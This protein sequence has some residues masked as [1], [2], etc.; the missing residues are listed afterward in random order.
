MLLA[1]QVVLRESLL[2]LP[3][4]N[5]DIYFL[6]LIPGYKINILPFHFL[7]GRSDEVYVSSTLIKE[8]TICSLD[9]YSLS[10]RISLNLLSKK[11]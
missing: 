9:S 3:M 10:T 6:E 11:A 7:C 5:P 1:K 4:H 2:K 8:I